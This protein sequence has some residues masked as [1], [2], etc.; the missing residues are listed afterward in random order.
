MARQASSAFLLWWML[1][2]VQLPFSVAFVKNGTDYLRNWLIMI[3]FSAVTVPGTC[4]LLNGMNRQIC[5][6]DNSIV[7]NRQC[8]SI[9]S[10]DSSSACQ[11]QDL[12]LSI[13]FDQCSCTY[14]EIK[15]DKPS[16]IPI[17][18]YLRLGISEPTCTPEQAAA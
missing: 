3:I 10:A 15:P 13:Q 1:G 8:C 9:S 2:L 7:S 6:Y 4:C 14:T 18:L 17:T 11:T 16:I 12:W 5:F